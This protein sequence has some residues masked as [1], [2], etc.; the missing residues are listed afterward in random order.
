MARPCSSTRAAHSQIDRCVDSAPSASGESN[1]FTS[2]PNV[3]P[4]ISTERSPSKETMAAGV[5]S[6]T[7]LVLLAN[8]LPTGHP[9]KSWLLLLAPSVSIAVTVICGRVKAAVSEYLRK[10]ELKALA[11]QLKHKLQEGLSNPSTSPD[12]RRQLTKDFELL[13]FLLVQADL[14]RIKKNLQIYH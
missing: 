2:V 7:L 1:K 14:K 5:G 9:W 12:H 4:G 11:E 13:E 3:S 10:R 6:G 8:N